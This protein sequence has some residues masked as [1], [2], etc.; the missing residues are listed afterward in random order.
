M[1]GYIEVGSVVSLIHYF[2]VKKGLLISLWCTMEQA[3]VRTIAFGR[4]TLDYQL[5]G[6]HLAV[7]SLLLGYSQCDLDIG[8]MFLNFLL[9]NTMKEMTGVDVQ[10]IRSKEAS[11]S[12]WENN[13]VL[14]FERWC[15]N[16][17]GLRD[18]PYRSIQLLSDL[19][20]DRSIRRSVGPLKS[21]P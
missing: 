19:I 20:E 16:W 11:E 6:R 5:C 14:G 1:K 2:Y 9:N 15:R 10:H 7:R 8:K 13:R 4:H 17:M 12:D 3:A 18:S 21:V